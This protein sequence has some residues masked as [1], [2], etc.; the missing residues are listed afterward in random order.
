MNQ[1]ALILILIPLIISIFDYLILKKEKK[2]K[3]EL[4][5]SA[6]ITFLFSYTIIAISY[7]LLSSVIENLKTIALVISSLSTI[8]LA[9]LR[10]KGRK[11]KE[12]LKKEVKKE[13]TLKEK[14]EEDVKGILIF[15]WILVVI[16]ISLTIF[17]IL[18]IKPNDTT[19]IILQ[20]ADPIIWILIVLWGQITKSFYPILIFTLIFL[21]S[22]IPVVMSLFLLKNPGPAIGTSLIISYFLI[23]GSISAYKLRKINT[24]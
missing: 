12:V 10:F 24:K 2:K 3:S 16:N 14:L 6:L 19:A 17:S 11:I 18:K 1:A 22:K 13:K 23:K 7:L 8:L 5:K 21:V 9:Y 15:I 4:I 20:I